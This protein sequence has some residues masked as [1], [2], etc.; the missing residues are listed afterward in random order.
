MK[1]SLKND[2]R[3]HYHYL[4][5]ECVLLPYYKNTV[6][7]D[8]E[9]EI[10]TDFLQNTTSK[11]NDIQILN[12]TFGTGFIYFRIKFNAKTNLS[13]LIANIKCQLSRK[14]KKN[15]ES[16]RLKKEATSRMWGNSYLLSS[17]HIT[18]KDIQEFAQDQFNFQINMN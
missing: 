11:L 2:G 7:L 15:P 5:T 12:L 6:Y 10:I 1:Q 8:S 13:S 4:T 16:L 18:L 17:E 14:L 9:K 3:N